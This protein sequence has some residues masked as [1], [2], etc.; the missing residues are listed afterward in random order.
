METMVIHKSNIFLIF[1]ISLHN[2]YS[3]T[4]IQ[5]NILGSD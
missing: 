1:F 5:Y 4:A 3:R 2:D